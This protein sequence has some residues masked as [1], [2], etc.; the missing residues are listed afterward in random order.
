M[1]QHAATYLLL[2]GVA[3]CPVG[4]TAG[5]KF[6]IQISS[7]RIENRLGRVHTRE[8]QH[9]PVHAQ[10]PCGAVAAAAA[11]VAPVEPALRSAAGTTNTSSG[12]RARNLWLMCLRRLLLPEFPIYAGRGT[13]LSLPHPR[14]RARDFG[15]YWRGMQGFVCAATSGNILGFF[16]CGSDAWLGVRVF[17][18]RKDFDPARW[19]R[20]N[21]PLRIR[22]V[23]N[24]FFFSRYMTG[25]VRLLTWSLFW[26]CFD[27]RCNRSWIQVTLGLFSISAESI[28]EHIFNNRDVEQQQVES[29]FESWGISHLSRYMPGMVGLVTQV[30]GRLLVKLNMQ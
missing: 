6:K 24:L 17:L 21:S 27:D 26:I 20:K 29:K 11:G 28:S 3:H 12:T 8:Q 14:R 13:M 18:F 1:Q 25:I 15:G 19:T 23:R 7:T 22:K 16:F 9:L 30:P 10:N 4:K 2:G 5:E